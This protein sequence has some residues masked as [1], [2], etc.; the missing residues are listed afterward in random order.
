MHAS[1]GYLEMI[2]KKGDERL[3]RLAIDCAR[4]EADLNALT[5]AASEFG[6]RRAGLDMQIEDHNE[7][8]VYKE[9]TAGRIFQSTIR[10]TWITTTITSGVRSN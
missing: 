5:M 4:G 7:A 8:A 3:V 2:R 10:M 6:T 1:P 9:A